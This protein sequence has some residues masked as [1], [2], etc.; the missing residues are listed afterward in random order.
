MT[1]D[2]LPVLR[3]RKKMIKYHLLYTLD[4]GKFCNIIACFQSFE[5]AEKWLELQG[6]VYWEIG[7][8]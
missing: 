1:A 2:E 5:D 7:L 4:S 6:A 3:L 8:L